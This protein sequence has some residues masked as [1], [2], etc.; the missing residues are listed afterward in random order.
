MLALDS[1]LKGKSIYLRPSMVKFR[2]SKSTD[3]EICATGHK[4]HPLYLNQQIIKIL[5]DMGVEDSFFLDLQW[6]AVENLRTTICTA[7]NAA[8]FLRK[9]SI[10]EDISL[11]W[12]IRELGSLKLSFHH[13]DFL[14]EVVET[15]IFAEIRALKYKGRI[16][17]KDGYTLLGIMDETNWLEED[18]IFCVVEENEE[19]RRIKGK[20]IITR[21]PA[22]HPGDVQWV[23]AVAVPDDSPLMRLRNCICFSQKGTRDLQASS[24]AEISMAMSIT[25]YLIRG[26]NLNNVS[27]LP[28]TLRR[29]LP[30]LTDPLLAMI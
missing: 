13:D 29:L 9:Q 18:E 3:L 22:L 7:R 25:S 5:E 10:G 14:L 1:R 27:C 15:A 28:I 4:P 23:S 6:M 19:V 21:S 11:P 30:A 26:Q 17:V 20:V 16:P 12:F 2:E 8:E 24:V